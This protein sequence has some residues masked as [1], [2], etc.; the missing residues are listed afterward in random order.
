MRRVHAT[1]VVMEKQYVTYSECVC[2]HRY[3]ACNALAPYCHL[4]PVLLYNN[5][6]H[7]LV[8]GTIFGKKV[9]KPKMCILI[10]STTFVSNVSHSNTN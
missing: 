4:W 3:S 2:S 5:L 6:P 10:S 8:K 1:I 7:Y 9:V